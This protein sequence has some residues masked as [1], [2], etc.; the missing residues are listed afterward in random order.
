MAGGPEHHFT[1]SREL[2]GLLEGDDGRM[3][4]SLIPTPVAGPAGLRNS[5]LAGAGR[6][7]R[8]RP[9]VLRRG[10]AQGNRATEGGGRAHRERVRGSQGDTALGRSLGLRSWSDARNGRAASAAPVQR[11]TVPLSGEDGSVGVSSIRASAMACA[12]E[13]FTS[14]CAM[15]SIAVLDV[16]PA[17]RADTRAEVARCAA[18]LARSGRGCCDRAIGEQGATRRVTTESPVSCQRIR[19]SAPGRSANSAL[20]RETT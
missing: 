19:S 7:S 18:S 10:A 12:P 5:Q 6:E 4:R 16:R 1:D 20:A 3:W 11:L 2:Y 9:V 8:D 13:G 14:F 17:P 15:T